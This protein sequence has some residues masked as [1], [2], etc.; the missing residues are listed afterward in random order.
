ME[1]IKA[2]LNARAKYVVGE[3]VKSRNFACY[4]VTAR[5][6]RRSEDAFYYDLREMPSPGTRQKALRKVP[7]NEIMPVK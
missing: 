2:E 7:E 5:Y 1:N 3:V 6:W 4:A